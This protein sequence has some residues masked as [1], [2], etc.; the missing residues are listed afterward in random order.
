MQDIPQPAVSDP[1]RL[2]NNTIATTST[3]SRNEKNKRT[4][5]QDSVGSISP[6][7]T[8]NH[9]GKKDEEAQAEMQMDTS[10]LIINQA[11]DNAVAIAHSQGQPSYVL[12]LE[13]FR[14]VVKNSADLAQLQLERRIVKEADI[15]KHKLPLCVQVRQNDQNLIRMYGN[16]YIPIL[17]GSNTFYLGECSQ[18]VSDPQNQERFCATFES[19]A[20][21]HVVINVHAVGSTKSSSSPSF[22]VSLVNHSKEEEKGYDGQGSGNEMGQVIVVSISLQDQL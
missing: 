18:T 6:A 11:H 2:E 14:Y 1:S 15:E 13:E 20:Q 7:I 16:R 8:A 12:S 19:D 10:D 4:E 17:T 21:D 22:S 3:S 9:N 5:V